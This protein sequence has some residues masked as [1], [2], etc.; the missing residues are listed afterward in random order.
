MSRLKFALVNSFFAIEQED[1]EE[2]AAEDDFFPL[3]EGGGEERFPLEVEGEEFIFFSSAIK[4]GARL[5]TTASRSD[6]SDRDWTPSQ[7]EKSGYNLSK[8]II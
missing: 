8:I 2:A 1:E 5:L 4:A 7:R 3:V 6:W